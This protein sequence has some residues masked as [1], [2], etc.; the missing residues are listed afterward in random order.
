MEETF[1]P[2]R[3]VL[4]IQYFPL[5]KYTE[6]YSASCDSIDV[7]EPFCKADLKHSF[8]NRRLLQEIDYVK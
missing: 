2:N 3:F 5:K 6:E 7:N 8:H 1:M 4:I